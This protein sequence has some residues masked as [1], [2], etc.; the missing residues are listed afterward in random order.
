MTK[1]IDG[2]SMLIYSPSEANY[3]GEAGF[4][5]RLRGTGVS[6]IIRSNN[7]RCWHARCDAVRESDLATCLCW[8]LIQLP[9][10]GKGSSS[11]IT[12]SNPQRMMITLVA[13]WRLPELH[14]YSVKGGR[15]E[16]RRLR[17]AVCPIPPSDRNTLIVHGMGCYRIY[18]RLPN[19]ACGKSERKKGS[20]RTDNALMD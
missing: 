6:D 3:F 12:G 15:P 14:G 5:R 17:P 16:D 20:L 19:E 8:T 7:R 13:F 10:Y 11:S 2:L 18:V 1:T 9:W 4:S